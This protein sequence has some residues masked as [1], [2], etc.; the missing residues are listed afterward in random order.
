MTRHPLE[1]ADTGGLWR[2]RWL[3]TPTS[4]DISTCVLWMQGQQLHVDL[5]LPAAAME[6]T[7][8]SSLSELNAHQLRTLAKAEGFAG[9]TTVKNSVC[10]WTRHINLQGPLKGIDTGR[11]RQT[12]DGL[13]ESGIHAQYEELW[14]QIDPTVPQA[15]MMTNSHG[16]TLVIL[17]TPTRFAMGRGWHERTIH[18]RS[19]PEHVDYALNC[20]NRAVLARAFD[21]EFCAGRIEDDH[22]IVEYSTHPMRSGSLA[23]D[24]TPLFCKAERIEVLITDFFGQTTL[25]EYRLPAR[26][27]AMA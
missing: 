22:G 18:T 19:L 24:A 17:W 25:E 13:L 11:L 21:Q 23:F 20:C 26:R 6:F 14:Q 15:R 27:M 1:L 10:T 16:Q 9:K 3:R 7:Q 8:A 5:R 2:R 12:P 4:E